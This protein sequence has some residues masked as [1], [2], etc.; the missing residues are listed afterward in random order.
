MKNSQLSGMMSLNSLTESM[1]WTSYIMIRQVSWANSV[2]TSSN[3]YIYQ[4][5]CIVWSFFIEGGGYRGSVSSFPW[6][7]LWFSG[8]PQLFFSCFPGFTTSPFRFS[9]EFVSILSTPVHIA[10][11][12]LMRRFLSVCLSVR[13]SVTLLKNHISDSIIDRSLK[14]YH[15]IK[16]F[17]CI[18]EKYRLHSKI[19]I[20]SSQVNQTENHTG[21]KSYLRKY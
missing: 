2:T 11:W 10:R 3:Y 4:A 16:P 18:Q 15:S 8:F 19:H 6:N 1:I 13:P 12:A 20:S 9:A 21:Q 7:I 17:R 5:L 14:L